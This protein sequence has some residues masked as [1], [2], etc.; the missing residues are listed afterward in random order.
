MHPCF[1]Q[2][3]DRVADRWPVEGRLAHLHGGI[4]AGY[5]MFDYTP[6]HRSAFDLAPHS[7]RLWLRSWMEDDYVEPLT[8]GRGGRVRF[9]TMVAACADYSQAKEARLKTS[10]SF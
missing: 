4:M 8:P 3:N 9:A 5:S 1:R 6:L 2:A 10:L 7:L